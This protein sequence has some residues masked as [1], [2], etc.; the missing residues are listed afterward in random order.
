MGRTGIKTVLRLAYLTGTIATIEKEFKCVIK[1]PQE[2]Q[3]VDLLHLSDYEQGDTDLSR[4]IGK[5]SMFV[6][7]FY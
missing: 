7:L 1:L 5:L 6:F 4:G 2:L 3:D